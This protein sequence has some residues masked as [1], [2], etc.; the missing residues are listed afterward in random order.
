[1]LRATGGGGSRTWFVPSPL[2][3]HFGFCP[4]RLDLGP[5]SLF[6]L[7]LGILFTSVCQGFINR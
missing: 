5:L 6:L 2:C 7:L 3:D 1:M 4:S